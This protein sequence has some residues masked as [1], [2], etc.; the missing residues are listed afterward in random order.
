MVI[1]TFTIPQSREVGSEC[2][3]LD[4]TDP[5]SNGDF[6]LGEKNS[7]ILLI[8]SGSPTIVP[9]FIQQNLVVAHREIS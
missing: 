3:M 9:K 5:T 1:P 2:P 8:S 7:S 4:L 6:R